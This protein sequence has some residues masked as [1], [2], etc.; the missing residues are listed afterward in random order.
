[1]SQIAGLVSVRRGGDG[2]GDIGLLLVSLE[3]VES[4]LIRVLGG[5][6]EQRSRG[7]VLSLRLVLVLMAKGAVPPVAVVAL[8]VSPPGNLRHVVAGGRPPV[9][10]IQVDVV[11]LQVE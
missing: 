5:R 10:V 11:V 8:L 3:S 2:G 1:M 4:Q 6:V 7:V 9:V